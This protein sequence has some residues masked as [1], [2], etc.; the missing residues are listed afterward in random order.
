VPEA[1]RHRST[2]KRHGM[3]ARTA[4]YQRYGTNPIFPI[5]WIVGAKPCPV[6]AQCESSPH[7][8]LPAGLARKLHAS[9]AADSYDD[10][11]RRFA[12]SLTCASIHG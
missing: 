5:W 1:H 12:H 9:V 11:W 4:C 7:C 2:K 3:A 10:A 8:G 6:G